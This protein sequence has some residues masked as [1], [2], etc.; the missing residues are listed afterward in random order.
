MVICARDGN[1]MFSRMKKELWKELA[2][3]GVAKNDFGH[4]FLLF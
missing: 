3:A 1:E 4:E 2:H